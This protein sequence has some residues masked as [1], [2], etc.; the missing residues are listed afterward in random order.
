[1]NDDRLKAFQ[2]L[3]DA[4]REMGK[5]LKLRRPLDRAQQVLDGLRELQRTQPFMWHDTALARRWFETLI[6]YIARAQTI[7]DNLTQQETPQ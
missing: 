5:A 1:M 7:V 3:A 6:Q 2:A 4:N